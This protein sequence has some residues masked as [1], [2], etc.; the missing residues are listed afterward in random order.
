MFIGDSLIFWKSKKQPTVSLSSA[1]AGY[2]AMSMVTKEMI[3]LSRL[4]TDLQVPFSPPAYLYCDSTTVL[5]IASNQVFHE[6]TKHIELDCHKVRETI[7]DGLLKTM[8]VRSDQQ[9]ADV[10]TMSLYPASSQET[11]RKMDLHNIYTPPS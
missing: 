6:C 9:L 8:Y 11:L 7:E 3:W 4:L 2:R 5:H 10:L 1:E